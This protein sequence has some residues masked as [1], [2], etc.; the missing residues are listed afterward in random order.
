MVI[1]LEPGAQ[2]EVSIG[3]AESI[4]EI[5]ALYEEFRAEIDPVLEDMGL[6]LLELG[7]HPTSL[8]QCLDLPFT[9]RSHPRNWRG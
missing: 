8:A 7:Y 4:R 2:L 1:T 6:K 9:K 3:P 5:E